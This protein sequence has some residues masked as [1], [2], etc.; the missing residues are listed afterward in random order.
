[1]TPILDAIDKDT[2]DLMDRCVEAASNAPR[3]TADQL[4]TDVYVSY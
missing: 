3:P 4:T 1:M 2:A